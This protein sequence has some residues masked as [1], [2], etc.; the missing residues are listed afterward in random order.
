MV[1][2]KNGMRK[3]TYCLPGSNIFYFYALR[4]ICPFRAH[5]RLWAVKT[6]RRLSP[7][8]T[9][10]TASWGAANGTQRTLS[11]FRWAAEIWSTTVIRGV[12]HERL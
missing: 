11:K 8:G 7:K 10:K 3:S 2:L 9:L 1:L 12:L 4:P 5:L 6:E